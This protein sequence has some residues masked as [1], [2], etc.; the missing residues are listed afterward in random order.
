MILES[1]VIQGTVANEIHDPNDS[2]HQSI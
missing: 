2:T 1:S